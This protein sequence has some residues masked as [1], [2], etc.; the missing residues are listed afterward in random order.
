MHI[1]RY[2]HAYVHIYTHTYIQA[3]MT[4]SYIVQYAGEAKMKLMI[5][6]KLAKSKIVKRKLG[7]YET[8]TLSA[9]THTHTCDTL[10]AKLVKHVSA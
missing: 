10:H 9:S 1:K 4:G 7:R 8:H 2:M 3:Y 5:T 6:G